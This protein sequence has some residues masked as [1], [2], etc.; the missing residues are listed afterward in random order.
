M[1]FFLLDTVALYDIRYDAIP[2]SMTLSTIFVSQQNITH[3][4]NII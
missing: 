1:K 4:E 3:R 2:F